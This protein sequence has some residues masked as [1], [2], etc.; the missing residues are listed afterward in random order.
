M[1]REAV[2][3]E[4]DL[5]GALLAA[6]NGHLGDARVLRQLDLQLLGD[7]L[8]LHGRGVRGAERVGEDRDVVDPAGDDERRHRAGRE[9]SGLL[10]ELRVDP[11]RRLVGVGPDEEADDDHPARGLR[12]R[13]DVLD[14]RDLVDRLL[15]GRR[16]P[17]LDLLGGGPR[18][19]EEDVDHRDLDLRLLL[20][21]R[22][23]DGERADEEGGDDDERRQL[24]LEERLRDPAGGAD[25][26]AGHLEAERL[27]L[28]VGVGRRRG[29]PRG[30]LGGL[31]GR[32]VAGLAH[33]A[34][35]EEALTGAPSAGACARPRR[36]SSPPFSPERTS[37]RSPSRV[38]SVTAR[39][40]AFPSS[41]F[42]TTRL[43][44]P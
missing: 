24:R 5:H 15:E 44:A 20:A 19:P 26:A 38:P 42:T 9:L 32:L 40:R 27:A 11:H 17:A 10:G 34:T 41:S 29:R 39:V 1:G 6:E 35:S 7:L 13:V 30:A 43:I 37:T 22:H 18:H 28:R 23:H 8:E 16:Q 36:T 2:A 25:G 3:V 12:D 33:F 4:G 21:R 14:V 31:A